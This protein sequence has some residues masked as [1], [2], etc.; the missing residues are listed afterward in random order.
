LGNESVRAVWLDVV[1]IDDLQNDLAGFTEARRRGVSKRWRKWPV[2]RKE[3][4]PACFL[5]V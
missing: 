4:D 1:A 2:V 3:R 5:R